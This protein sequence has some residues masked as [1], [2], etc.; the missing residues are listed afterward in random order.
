MVKYI[1]D[2]GDIVWLEFGP[3]KGREIQKT[4]LL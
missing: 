1:P 4:D 3:Q 2:R